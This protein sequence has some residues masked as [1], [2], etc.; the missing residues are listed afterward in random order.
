VH[1]FARK[2]YELLKSL[3]HPSIVRVEALHSSG[4]QTWMVMELCAGGSLKS[5]VEEN[6]PFTEDFALDFFK[7]LLEAVDYL[8]TKRIV[9]RDLKPDNLMFDTWPG[10]LK[11]IDFNS[12]T[13][14]GSDPVSC[15]PMLS[16]RGAE[17][18]RSP[19]QLLGLIW[20]ERAD[21]WACG[22]CLYFAVQGK[23]P[24]TC[25]GQMAKELFA[26]GC[27]PEVCWDGISP[28]CQHLLR[29][30][31]AIDMRDR[32]P[33]M[34]LLNTAL[35]KPLQRQR[36]SWELPQTTING[37]DASLN[38]F[39]SAP[40]AVHTHTP[41]HVGGGY[42]SLDCLH[43]SF[44]DPPTSAPR[45]SLTSLQLRKFFRMDNAGSKAIGSPR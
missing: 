2:E 21:I 14:I 4:H 42:G 30:C 19:E 34:E 7:Q 24:F 11:V 23:F 12:A 1:T 20:N 5:C 8:H 32:P 6:G 38:S 27:M 17:I 18:Y 29:Q 36:L 10:T 31:L 9:H 26:E 35:F 15:G 33:A 37:I 43:Q 28:E 13:Q 40:D 44:L 16:M 41:L 45:K 39:I 3:Q 25:T 22:L